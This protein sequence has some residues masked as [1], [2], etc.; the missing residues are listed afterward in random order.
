[1]LLAQ[2][3]RALN[4]SFAVLLM[5]ASYEAVDQLDFLP[6]DTFQKNFWLLR[7]SETE[8]YSLQ[9]SP[10]KARTGD[11]TDPLYFDFIA[12]S[13]YATIG[14]EIPKGQQVSERYDRPKLCPFQACH[15]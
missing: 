7:Q 13:Q 8:S 3:R 9:Y 10:L 4:Q 1:M 5:R 14:N 11:L 12:F 6:M 2:C 15:C